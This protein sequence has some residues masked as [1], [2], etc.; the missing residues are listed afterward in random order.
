MR[1]LFSHLEHPAK[2]IGRGQKCSRAIYLFAC[3]DWPRNNSPLSISTVF[4]G[5]TAEGEPCTACVNA[6][7]S[8]HNTQNSVVEK[9]TRSKLSRRR[10]SKV[11]AKRRGAVRG[12]PR[13]REKC[14]PRIL[15]IEKRNF[16]TTGDGTPNERPPTVISY[17]YGCAALGQGACLPPLSF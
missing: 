6:R 17:G 12:A 15:T 7:R 10:F 5:G 2:K 11:V 14:L 16:P 13:K 4:W 1:V 3:S 8:P 9:E